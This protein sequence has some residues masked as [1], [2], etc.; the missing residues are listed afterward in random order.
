MERKNKKK[1]EKGVVKKNSTVMEVKPVLQTPGLCGPA[2]L[3]MVLEYYG[4]RVSEGRVARLSCATKGK[5]TTAEGII[6]AAKS[7]GLHALLKDNSS[8]ADL[9]YFVKRNIPVIVDWFEEDDGH[10][11]VVFHIEEGKIFLANSSSN[12]RKAKEVEMPA[13]KFLR[14]WFDFPGPFIER[15]RDIIL[16]RMIVLTPSREK[17]PAFNAKTK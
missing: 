7:F 1:E 11:S 8:I 5:G 14:V 13:E 3:R 10:Y 9:D 4:I 16:R 6:K 15:K 2:A 17:S 12:I